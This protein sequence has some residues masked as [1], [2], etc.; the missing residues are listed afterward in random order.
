MGVSDLE[1]KLEPQWVRAGLPRH[2]LCEEH[3]VVELTR[4][5]LGMSRHGERRWLV[6][7]EVR[8]VAP[9][10]GRV[11]GQPTPYVRAAP[12][13]PTVT[14]GCLERLLAGERVAYPVVQAVQS[15]FGVPLVSD[16]D[17]FVLPQ[18][19][20]SG[21]EGVSLDFVEIVASHVGPCDL[22][23]RWLCIDSTRNIQFN[24]QDL[25]ALFD[26]PLIL[27]PGMAGVPLTPAEAG[28]VVHWQS[29]D[30]FDGVACFQLS[31]LRQ[32]EFVR[33][34]VTAVPV[35]GLNPAPAPRYGLACARLPLIRQLQELGGADGRQQCVRTL[36]RIAFVADGTFEIKVF[37]LWL[38]LCLCLRLLFFFFFFFF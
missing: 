18:W 37:F 35:P 30:V 5:H 22:G 27:P 13:S 32:Y 1:T 26:A 7:D 25:I 9:N 11:L 28:L 19:G 12:C 4:Y 6:V 24:P 16:G 38:Y 20:P 31:T 8:V 15:D 10:P 14:H 2:G 36:C 34:D 3:A 29:T 33:F 17:C 23:P 21:C